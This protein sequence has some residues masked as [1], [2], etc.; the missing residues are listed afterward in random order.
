MARAAIYWAK[1]PWRSDPSVMTVV[2]PLSSVQFCMVRTMT[3]SP[4]RAGSTFAPTAM[5]LP[6]QSAPWICGKLSA[7]PSHVP[8][9]VSVVTSVSAVLPVTDL[10]YQPVR[11]LM[12]VLLTPAARTLSRTSFAPICGTGR[13]SRHC[14]MSSPPC[15]IRAMPDIVAARVIG[16]Q[17]D[18]VWPGSGGLWWW[19]A[20]VRSPAGVCVGD[21][22]TGRSPN[23]KRKA[24]SA[25]CRSAVVL[26]AGRGWQSRA[27]GFDVDAKHF[28]GGVKVWRALCADSVCEGVFRHP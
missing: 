8:S 25:T 11:V 26:L 24:A 16:C 9:E 21:Y 19:F 15:P 6:Q 4:M 17:P 14:S 13:S 28:G 18:A 20:F 12:S 3:R 10:E 7:W 5:T 1:A 2:L 23:G 27:Q 22:W